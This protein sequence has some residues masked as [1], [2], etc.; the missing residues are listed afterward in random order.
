MQ[1]K[2]IF[3]VFPSQQRLL[4][5]GEEQIVTNLEMRSLVKVCWSNRGRW[6]EE[7]LLASGHLTREQWR[8]DK[9]GGGRQGRRRKGVR[10]TN[11]IP[12]GSHPWAF[13]GK[14]SVPWEMEQ[15][16]GNLTKE[17]VVIKSVFVFVIKSVF[18]FVAK[19][20]LVFVANVVFVFVTQ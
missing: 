9:L 11:T 3:A 13:N 15:K 7:R 12:P 18:V 5:G 8:K 2:M 4:R 1:R 10:K 16:I 14:N 17:I 19:L 20:V 6:G